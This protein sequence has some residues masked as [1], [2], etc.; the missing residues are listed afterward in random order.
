MIERQLVNQECRVHEFAIEGL[1]AVLDVRLNE[2]TAKLPT[3]GLNNASCP[4]ALLKVRLFCRVTPF[5]S[6]SFNVK[7]AAL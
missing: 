3:R 6:L 5:Q 2:S 1:R 4:Q 7:N